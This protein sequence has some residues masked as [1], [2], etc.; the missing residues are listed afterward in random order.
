[1]KGAIW[2]SVAR[3]KLL[4]ANGP[5]ERLG[6]DALLCDWDVC[7]CHLPSSQVPVSKS[8]GLSLIGAIDEAEPPGVLPL[9]LFYS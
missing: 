3:I 7:I 9:L 1:M 8:A 5:E 2:R 4:R 6:R